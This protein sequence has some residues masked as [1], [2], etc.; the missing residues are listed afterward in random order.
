VADANTAEAQVARLT[1][2]APGRRQLEEVAFGRYMMS[3]SPAYAALWGYGVIGIPPSRLTPRL[4]AIS[5]AS[6]EPRASRIREAIAAARAG[7]QEA[8]SVVREI[9]FDPAT[10]ANLSLQ[11]VQNKIFETHGP[12]PVDGYSLYFEATG[13]QDAASAREYYRSNSVGV[14]VDRI[15]PATHS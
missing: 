5:V 4:R 13:N 15:C 11:D 7:D 12:Y 6:N 8:D 10:D 3:R 2:A 14:W 1:W 9:G